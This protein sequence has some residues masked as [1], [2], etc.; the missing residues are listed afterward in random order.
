METVKE[1]VIVEGT[2]EVVEKEITKV[3]EVEM[4]VTATPE[5]EEEPAEDAKM[6]LRVGTGDS[7][8]GLNPHQEIIARFEEENPDILVQLEAVS[9]RD[10]YTRLLTQIAAGDAPDI[11]QIGDDAVPMFVGKGAFLPLDE[12]I[13]W[14]LSFGYQHLSPRCP[15]TWPVGGSAVDVGQGLSPPGRLL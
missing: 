8:E 6:I 10:Y 14:R 4:V 13:S 5:P 7:G 1:T 12:F 2:P 9:G 11:M 3:V 15:G